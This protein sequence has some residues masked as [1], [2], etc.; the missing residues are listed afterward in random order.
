VILIANNPVAGGSTGV[1][2][3]SRAGF[4]RRCFIKTT[5]KEQGCFARY[6]LL[7]LIATATVT[8]C[9]KSNTLLQ[10]TGRIQAVYAG[11]LPRDKGGETS[12]HFDPKFLSFATIE[13]GCS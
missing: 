13:I 5:G 1:Q 3:Q 7:P 9:F 6:L 12:K 2:C 8:G 11:K 10:N 4:Y